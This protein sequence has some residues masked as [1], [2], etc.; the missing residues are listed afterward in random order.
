MPHTAVKA[1]GVKSIVVRN[2]GTRAASVFLSCEP[3][4]T[5]SI[6]PAQVVVP[7]GV[8]SQLE[9]GFNPDRSVR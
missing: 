7:V 2:L 8:S 6:K 9:V 4:K 5:F 1:N 3:A